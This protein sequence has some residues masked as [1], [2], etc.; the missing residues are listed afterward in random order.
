MKARTKIIIPAVVF[1]ATGLLYLFAVAGG[2]PP[3]FEGMR[4]TLYSDYSVQGIEIH[5]DYPPTVITDRDL[6]GA[7]ELK[8]LI[9][10]ALS[11]EYPLN[12]E[13]SVF[14][15]FEDLEAVSYE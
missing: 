11:K 6:E 12:T 14:I 9:H 1:L 2:Y 3:Y 13:G 4:L 15:S 7:P 8:G 5:P 10:E